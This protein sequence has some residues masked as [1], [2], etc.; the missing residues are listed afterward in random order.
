MVQDA[1][2]A[3]GF[4]ATSTG[5]TTKVTGDHSFSAGLS[6]QANG[7]AS[8][9]SGKLTVANGDF[10][11]ALGEGILKLVLKPA[12]ASGAASSATRK[13][14]Q[15]HLVWELQQAARR[16]I[17]MGSGTEASGTSA[18]ATGGATESSG[19]YY[20]FSAGQYSLAQGNHAMQ[21]L[22]LLLMAVG[23]SSFAA[24]ESS[25]AELHAT[26]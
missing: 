8:L 2:S 6:T 19:N 4:A 1:T 11:A 12:F 25:A 18:T 3:E 13:I 26:V 7:E 17:A 23:A 16:S 20:S 9:T 24:G 14:T 21:P 5:F 15:Q 22:V 10:A